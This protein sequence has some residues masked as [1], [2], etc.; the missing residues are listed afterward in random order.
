MRLNRE[1]QT[2]EGGVKG[3]EENFTT[4]SK[5]HRCPYCPYNTSNILLLRKHMETH[6]GDKLYPLAQFTF[7]TDDRR[8]CTA[9][10]ASPSR[11]KPYPCLIYPL[12]GTEKGGLKVHMR[13]HTDERPFECPHCPSK[14]AQKVTVKSD[15]TSQGE[16][17]GAD[18]TFISGAKLNQCPYC[19]F[20][21][22]DS[23]A[24]LQHLITHTE[25]HTYS[26]TECPYRTVSKINFTSHIRA[27]TGEKSYPCRYC[28]FRT[29]FEYNLK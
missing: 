1:E 22:F 18:D 25:D 26:C 21:N 12:S 20:T 10:H 28:P 2:P 5:L 6:S 8:Y 17:P 4:V 15:R 29:S 13:T 23:D 16:V 9:H 7:S 27:H 3:K 19:P 11:E 14:F 24:L